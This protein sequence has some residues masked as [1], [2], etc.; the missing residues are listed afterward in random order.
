MLSASVLIHHAPLASS[1]TSSGSLEL[2]SCAATIARDRVAIVAL[3]ASRGIPVSI[4]AYRRC[5]ICIT[6]SRVDPCF[7][8]A[9]KI[10]AVAGLTAAVI[11]LLAAVDRVVSALE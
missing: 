4:S 8:L 2:A 11:A 5:A 10:T 1:Q 6:L 7:A 3:F 9:F